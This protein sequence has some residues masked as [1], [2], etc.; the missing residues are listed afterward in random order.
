MRGQ[1]LH[2]WPIWNQEIPSDLSTKMLGDTLKAIFMYLILIQFKTFQPRIYFN[3]FIIEICP[4]ERHL[5]FNK[6]HKMGDKFNLKFIPVLEIQPY[7]QFSS[8]HVNSHIIKMFV[9]IICQTCNTCNR[10][11]LWL[12]F[13][14]K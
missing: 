10:C 12:P 4:L 13:P 5:S 3:L 14:D 9:N 1:N 8:W 11:N 7:S 6:K 2:G